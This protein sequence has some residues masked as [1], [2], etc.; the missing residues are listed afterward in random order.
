MKKLFTI[1]ALLSVAF[2]A[3]AQNISDIAWLRKVKVQT[4]IDAVGNGVKGK[5]FF[6]AP[7]NCKTNDVTGVYFVENSY[8]DSNDMHQPIHVTGLIYHDT[9]DGKEYLGIKVVEELYKSESDVQPCAYMER[10]IKL[11]DVSAQYI[12]DTSTGDTE[13]KF[14]PVLPYTETTN[15]RTKYPTISFCPNNNHPHAID[16]GLPSGTKW[17]CCNVGATKSEEEGGYYAWGETEEKD[18][19]NEVTY[20]YCT[21]ENPNDYGWY[22]QNIQYQ[23]IGK[24]ISG[25][26]YDVAHV[27]WGGSWVMPSVE[28]LRELLDNCTYECTDLNGVK[29]GKFTS[30]TNG[31]SIFLPAADFRSNDYIIGIGSSGSYWSSTSQYL[32]NV[33]KAYTLAFHPDSAHWNDVADLHD[34]YHGRTVRPVCK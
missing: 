1:L 29:G 21:G 15:P 13:W 9:G 28:Q 11:D 26:K 34:R 32:S 30:K 4:S 19:Y 24:D 17:A 22:R 6:V 12:I 5:I 7:K 10:E 33:N 20:Q 14:D 27:K 18:A 25:T 16:L 3:N 8:K 23:Y 2:T 31:A